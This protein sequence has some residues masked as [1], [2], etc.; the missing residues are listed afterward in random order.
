MKRVPSI[1]IHSHI[2]NVTDLPSAEFVVK[3]LLRV[4]E[5]FPDKS[6]RFRDRL[7]A[8]VE[9]FMQRAVDWFRPPTGKEEAEILGARGYD[10]LEKPEELVSDD[11][12]EKRTLVEPESPALDSGLIFSGME[13]EEAL[14]D[15]QFQA[16]LELFLTELITPETPNGE[17]DPIDQELFDWITGDEDG[18]GLS[19][20]QIARIRPQNIGSFSDLSSP[21]GLNPVL[22]SGVFEK[23]RRGCRIVAIFGFLRRMIDY[24]Y[25]NARRMLKLYHWTRDGIDLFT[26]TLV[27]LSFW[28]GSAPDPATPLDSRGDEVGQLDLLEMICRATRGRIHGYVPFCP[29][30]NWRANGES[31]AWAKDAVHRLGFIGVKLYPPMG[32]APAGNAGRMFHPHQQLPVEGGKIDEQLRELFTWCNREEVPILV[33][34]SNTNH[35]HTDY[36]NDERT[37]PRHWE[38]VLREFPKLRV[39][40]GHFGGLAHD[41]AENPNGDTPWADEIVRLIHEFPGQVF[42]DLSF[43][44]EI[45]NPSFRQTYASKLNRY[46]NEAGDGGERLRKQLLYGSDWHMLAMEPDHEDY[47]HEM[48]TLLSNAGLDLEKAMG[49]NALNFLGLSPGARGRARIEA[50]YGRVNISPPA[51]LVGTR[52]IVKSVDQDGSTITVGI[53]RAG[54]VRIS[55]WEGGR[56]VHTITQVFA[57]ENSTIAEEWD[58]LDGFGRPLPPGRYAIRVEAD[59]RLVLDPAFGQNGTG[60]LEGIANPQRIVPG[61]NGQFWVVDR[62]SSPSADHPTRSR[63]YDRD[64]RSELKT[65]NHELA[66]IVSTDRGFRPGAKYLVQRLGLDHSLT[67]LDE[68]GNILQQI[69]A[70]L[71][72][73]D[74]GE[75]QYTDQSTLTPDFIGFGPWSSVYFEAHRRLM[76]YDGRATFG[77]QGFRM[78]T[79]GE[80]DPTANP[81]TGTG[82]LVGHHPAGVVNGIRPEI[83]F[84]KAGTLLLKFRDLGDDEVEGNQFELVDLFDSRKDGGTRWGNRHANGPATDGQ[85]GIY[86]VNR[87]QGAIEKI[88]DTD[89]CGKAEPTPDPYPAYKNA[90]RRLKAL[91]ADFG[92]G[93]APDT[94]RG[95]RHCLFLD[96]QLYLVEDNGVETPRRRDGNRRVSR[97]NI[98]FA[99]RHELSVTVN[100]GQPAPLPDNFFFEDPVRVLGPEHEPEV[101]DKTKI[102]LNAPALYQRSIY[103]DRKAR[104][105]I[106]SAAA[107][108]KH[109][110]DQ[111]IGVNPDNPDSDQS[112]HIHSDPNQGGIHLVSLNS[113]QCPD[114]AASLLPEG[115][116]AFLVDERGSDLDPQLWIIGRTALGVSHGVYA[117]LKKLGFRWLLPGDNWTIA[118]SGDDIRLQGGSLYGAPGFRQREFSVA[119]FG[120]IRSADQPAA[121]DDP[122]IHKQT[123]TRF[124]RFK[125]RNLLGGEIDTDGHMGPTFNQDANNRKILGDKDHPD[126]HPEYRAAWK[127]DIDHDQPRQN[128]EDARWPYHTEVKHCNS[129]PDLQELWAN[130]WVNRYF[131]VNFGPDPFGEGQIKVASVDPSDGGLEDPP[132][133]VD[134]DPQNS[135]ARLN[136]CICKKCDELGSISNRVHTLSNAV[137]DAIARYYP[138]TGVDP[139]TGEGDGVPRMV[140]VAAHNQHREPPDFALRPNVLVNFVRWPMPQDL[141]DRWKRAVGGDDSHLTMWEGWSWGDDFPQGYERFGPN[142]IQD[143]LACR[144][145]AASLMTTYSPVAM[146]LVWTVAA[147]VLWDPEQDGGSA[148]DDFFEQGFGPAKAPVRSMFERWFRT[149][150]DVELPDDISTDQRWVQIQEERKVTPLELRLSFLDLEEALGLCQTTGQENRVRDLVLYVQFLRLSHEYQQADGRDRRNAVRDLVEYIWQ[151]YDRHLIDCWRLTVDVLWKAEME[152]LR[153]LIGYDTGEEVDPRKIWGLVRDPPRDRAIERMIEDG[154][155]E[156]Q[157]SDPVS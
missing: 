56:R 50:Y 121:C 46:L 43:H 70:T 137:A 110:L 83:Y 5:H 108:L 157:E 124:E 37:H 91:P 99:E 88:Y 119:A 65:I 52:P 82:A 125:K 96:E 100:R 115:R 126:Y 120:W 148:V 111:M 105:E 130:W 98:A 131:Y 127:R 94:F 3:V 29:L 101:C 149:F 129:N 97:W 51:W 113:E 62:S 136:H 93:R 107:E 155:R 150:Q 151:I 32:F 53:E 21:G 26:P 102:A 90:F 57:A 84:L 139:E 117:Y 112:F 61:E 135:K 34:C 79:D 134:A 106:E 116:E 118:P 44:D 41:L 7:E 55:V 33:H 42:A 122:P 11:L 103:I 22:S 80:D 143:W 75:N 156:Y 14:R 63:C 59:E 54:D 154:K 47:P 104:P 27:D 146:S 58:G 74:E 40:M 45:L 1:D 86:I 152:K 24:R 133:G 145:D 4:G 12:E 23:P 85:G 141:I 109:W 66:A 25:H 38:G 89:W 17:V 132:D 123:E 68:A 48:R 138:N 87:G 78:H 144:I 36:K 60:F 114:D 128:Q 2:F 19:E 8:K 28:I 39:C 147:S 153:G 67:V 9:R 92:R 16:A 73:C 81:P 71:T 64:G 77:F 30:R 142:R 76:A 10:P 49:G 35:S 6:Q 13:E 15:A 140:S 20:D 95:G 72:V 69:G 18:F 31:L